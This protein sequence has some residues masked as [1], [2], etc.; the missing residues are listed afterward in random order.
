MLKVWNT[1]MNFWTWT[2]FGDFIVS[3]LWNCCRQLVYE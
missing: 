1:A 3:W 2:S